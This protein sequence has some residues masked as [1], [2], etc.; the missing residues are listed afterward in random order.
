MLQHRLPDGQEA[1][2]LERA[3]VVRGIPL[4]TQSSTVLADP[5]GRKRAQDRALVR[6]FW[7]PVVQ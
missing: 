5:H 2:D 3:A 4:R 1:A 6:Q 7:E